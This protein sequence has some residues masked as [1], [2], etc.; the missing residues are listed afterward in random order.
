MAL[1]TV[2][3]SDSDKW[4]NKKLLQQMNVDRQKRKYSGESQDPPEV[5]SSRHVQMAG[6]CSVLASKTLPPPEQKGNV[7]L[8]LLLLLLP[9]MVLLVLALPLV[10]AAAAVNRSA[11]STCSPHP[12][13]ESS[14]MSNC[15]SVIFPRSDNGR[16]LFLAKAAVA[17]ASIAATA[18]SL[19]KL[20]EAVSPC[21]CCCFS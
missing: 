10:V 5:I 20:R 18:V 17:A 8:L 2:R 3:R 7:V 16:A 21:C 1:Y 6:G 4:L 14:N 15:C 13:K 11:R 12:A 19:L 9:P